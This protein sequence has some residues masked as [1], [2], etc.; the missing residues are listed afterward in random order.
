MFFIVSSSISQTGCFEHFIKK[1]EE[2]QT[3]V[4]MFL[5]SLEEAAVGQTPPPSVCRWVDESTTLIQAKMSRRL[6]EG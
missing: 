3:N 6:L 1:A 5:G 2:A 4:K